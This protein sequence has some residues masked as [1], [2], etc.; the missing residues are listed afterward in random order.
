L[1]QAIGNKEARVTATPSPTICWAEPATGKVGEHLAWEGTPLI[2][3]KAVYV[4]LSR[5]RGN[6]TATA[7]CCF[8]A[9]TGLL[10]WE[11]EVCEAVEFSE[12]APPRCRNHLL[13]LAGPN[14]VYCSNAG[15]V[16]ALDAATGNHVWAVR[17]ASRGLKTREGQRSPRDL[18]PPL[19]AGHRIVLAPADI[20][21]LFCFDAATGQT[22]WERDGIE[23]S[24]LIGVSHDR[25]V[26]T[27]P[28]GLGAVHV[29]T[30]ENDGGW[31]QPLLG[32]LASL[33]RPFIADAWVFWPTADA[34]L[35]WRAVN[36]LDGKLVRG[37][38]SYDAGLLRPLVT[39]N[40]ALGHGCLVIA[41]GE[42]LVG[43]VPPQPPLGPPRT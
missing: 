24:H 34:K 1:P 2:H 43:Y 12:T 29:A 19:A 35:P 9:Q 42:E 4:A 31:R 20:D 25:V 30:G 23:I 5:I 11:Q 8:E 40:A 33:G 16:V 22:L 7:I 3:H 14:V 6:R 27:T 37:P 38:E 17:Y 41:T 13:T 15:A 26:F 39:G 21:R 36:L 28:K 18:C 10:R 32:N